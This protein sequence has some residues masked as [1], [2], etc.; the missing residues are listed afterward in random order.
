MQNQQ[1]SKS[2]IYSCC[3]RK[4]STQGGVS[5]QIQHSASP[6]AVFATHSHPECCIFL[7]NTH[8]SALTSI[9]CLLR[10]QI[11]EKSSIAFT[12]KCLVCCF[13]YQVCCIGNT[14]MWLANTVQLFQ[15]SSA[16]AAVSNPLDNYCLPIWILNTP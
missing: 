11:K 5:W 12:I 16:T 3:T 7:Y 6:R 13:R 4:Y 10:G 1:I 15:L 8:N 9:Y 2:T 14:V